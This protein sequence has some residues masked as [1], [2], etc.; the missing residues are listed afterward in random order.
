MGAVVT[1]ILVVRAFGG[2][3]GLAAALGTAVWF[4]LCST[5]MGWIGVGLWRGGQWARTPA[6][7]AQLLLLGAA[8][9]AVGPSSR[10]E[11]G[12]PAA[13]YCALVLAL[14]FARSTSRWA[15]G[16]DDVSSTR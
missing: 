16:D 9:Y 4:A 8:W 3:D 6:V 7:V 12:V 14:L 10:P 2:P 1:M 11:Y 5:A 15:Y 13:V